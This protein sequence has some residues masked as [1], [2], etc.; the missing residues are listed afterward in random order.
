MDHMPWQALVFQSIP[1][2]IIVT[3]LGLGL[4]GYY[5]PFKYVVSIGLINSLFSF[6]LLRRLPL[7]FGLHTL[8]HLVLL[9]F[10]IKIIIKKIEW[11]HAVTAVLL[12]TAVLGLAESIFIP[13][14]LQL[15]G[16]TMDQVL[17]DTWL[18]VFFPLPH[19]TVLG[20]LAYFIWRRRISLPA[21]GT[22]VEGK[23]DV[24]SHD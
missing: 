14:L 13:V 24:D 8:M 18:R 17:R 22:P 2:G 6:F 21:F 10:L 19:E 23:R 5:P 15:T 12:G 11:W 7:P 1:E 20:I 16:L 3:G 4:L 9:V